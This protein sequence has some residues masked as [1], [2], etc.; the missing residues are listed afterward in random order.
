M[1]RL[2]ALAGVPMTDER[3]ASTALALPV[4]RA[5]AAALSAVDYGDVDPA[6]GFRPPRGPR[7]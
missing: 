4:A 3:I 6:G 5:V 7:A 1:R 2:A